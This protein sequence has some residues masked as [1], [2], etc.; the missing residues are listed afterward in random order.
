M[1]KVRNAGVIILF[2][3]MAP[4]IAQQS[5]GH[6]PPREFLLKSL[7]AAVPNYLDSFHQDTG[8]FGAEPWI[9]QD[10]NV[11]FPLAAAWAIEDPSN[12]WF[13]KQELLDVIAKAGEVLTKE[14]DSKGKWTFRKKDNSTWGQIHMPWTYS[15]WI[16]AYQLVR[17]ALPTAAR[18]SW[19]KGLMLGFS[20]IRACAGG[21]LHNIPTHHAMALYIAGI[22]FE[23]DD[24]KQAAKSYMARVVAAQDPAGFWTEHA[25]PVVGYNL[26]YIDAL[27]VYYHFS[28]DPLVL[29]ALTR[30]AQFHASVLWPNGSS[31]PAIDERQIYH[32]G[33]NIG[34]VGFSWTPEGRGFLLKQVAAFS[35]DAGKTVDADYAASMLLYGGS[36]DAKFPP[37]DQD[38]ATVIIGDN[39]AL[40]QRKKPW[41]WALSAYA[42]KPSDSRWIQDRQNFLDIY[43]DALGLVVGGGNTKLQP[44]WST[45]TVGNPALLKHVPGDA[46]PNFVPAIDLKWMPDEASL[47]HENTRSSL[48]LKYG[49][50]ECQVSLSVNDNQSLS[51]TCH[52]PKGRGVEAHVPLLYRAPEFTTAPGKSIPLTEEDLLLESD[53]LGNFIIYD[54]LKITIPPTARLRWPAR[55]HNPYKKDGSSSLEAAKLV[56]VLPFDSIEE[57]TL[58]MSINR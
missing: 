34:N 45:F 17:D 39:K 5:F 15:R 55:Q 23:N 2:L 35:H 28:K 47:T 13:H 19:E 12:P 24:W 52:A 4:A 56:I 11:I 3:V 31:V 26:V 27:G 6:W 41:Q 22:C 21:N 37:A 14:M 30:S 38:V 42:C 25:G 58:T 29:G 53:A 43:H 8:R 40:I 20:G 10:Q 16:R 50:I 44:Y 36:G 18:E 51:V 9:C 54:D 33:V 49:D 57:Y 1:S 48:S 32:D 46:D 7:V